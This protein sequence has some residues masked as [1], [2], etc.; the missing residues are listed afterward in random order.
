MLAY[1]SFQKLYLFC[2]VIAV[3]PANAARNSRQPTHTILETR[4]EC[5]AFRC[6]Q[7]AD[8]F[9]Q[10]GFEAVVERLV[11]V[12]VLSA[13]PNWLVKSVPLLT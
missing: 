8:H 5:C 7:Q 10:H 3:S 12:A 9:V 6:P 1:L 13:S 11:D 2:N 4:I